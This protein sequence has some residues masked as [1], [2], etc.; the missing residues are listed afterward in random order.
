[1]KV[2]WPLLVQIL[3]QI[4]IRGSFFTNANEPS[5]NC[6]K[7]GSTFHLIQS[8]NVLKECKLPSGRPI[9][10]AAVVNHTFAE[11]P[12]AGFFG[13]SMGEKGVGLSYHPPLTGPT[14]PTKHAPHSNK[15][16][17]TVCHIHKRYVSSPWELEQLAVAG[18]VDRTPNVQPSSK[19]DSARRRA[20][21]DYI[22][23]EQY[24]S[25]ATRW[26]RRITAHMRGPEAPAEAED[27][28]F[29]SRFEVTRTCAG[30]K[31]AETWLE[32]IEVSNNICSWLDSFYSAT[33][34][35]SYF[36]HTPLNYLLY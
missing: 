33:D 27:Y 30:E 22:Q 34:I 29:L 16:L 5:E 23:S 7:W 21:F 12:D 24:V 8:K 2:L 17:R 13:V 4:S 18:R 19:S 35:H 11:G 10:C 28:E 26:L 36:S 25:N 9:C 1:M 20:L 14:S 6:V 32:W 3:L 31:E 15:A